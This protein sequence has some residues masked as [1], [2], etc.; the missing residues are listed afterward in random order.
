MEL[1]PP[2]TLQSSIIAELESNGAQSS[3]SS[4]PSLSSSPSQTS[5]D[6]SPSLLVWLIFESFG[7][8]SETS[9]TVSS[10][11]SPSTTVP[12]PSVAPEQKLQPD[13]NT[14]VSEESVAFAL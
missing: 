5:P 13:A 10:S 3:L 8:L 11:V 9:H 2:Q 14:Q 7:Q 12:V 1:S 6:E 4:T